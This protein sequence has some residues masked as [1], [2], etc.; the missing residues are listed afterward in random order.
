MNKTLNSSKQKQK[1]NSKTTMNTM[2][3]DRRNIKYCTTVLSDAMTNMDVTDIHH[4]LL[5]GVSKMILT[6]NIIQNENTAMKK[7]EDCT[8]EEK[9][10]LLDWL[11]TEMESFDI[12]S[13][14]KHLDILVTKLLVKKLHDYKKIHG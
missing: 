12:Y 2:L 13:K 4:G 8:E 1:I 3:H 7:L 14:N 9:E 5:C 11:I 6:D 10:E